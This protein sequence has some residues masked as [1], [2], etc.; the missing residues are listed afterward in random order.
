ME[1]ERT[2]L[3]ARECVCVCER[4]RAHTP[5]GVRRPRPASSPASASP[6]RRAATPSPPPTPRAPPPFGRACC[7]AASPTLRG[8]RGGR[9]RRGAFNECAVDGGAQSPN[10]EP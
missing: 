6:P 5:A 1:R 8:A 7:D 10:A 9:W 3:L 4:E 2:H